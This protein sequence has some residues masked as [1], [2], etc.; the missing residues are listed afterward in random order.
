MTGKVPASLPADS[1][2]SRQVVKGPSGQ[3]A[4]LLS[5]RPRA[6][7]EEVANLAAVR[8]PRQVAPSLAVTKE[9]LQGTSSIREADT[10]LSVSLRRVAS[11]REPPS[12]TVPSAGARGPPLRSLRRPSPALSGR[13]A[14]RFRS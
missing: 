1:V 6:A 2:I 14:R 5:L 13:S 4:D 12:L 8:A 7:Q 9:N 10:L 11:R 3:Q